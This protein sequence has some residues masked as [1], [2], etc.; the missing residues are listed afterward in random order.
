MKY[1]LS[2]VVAFLLLVPTCL[3]QDTNKSLDLFKNKVLPILD[4]KCVECHNSKDKKKGGLELDSAEGLR[5]GGSSGRVVIPHEPNKSPLLLAVS[6]SDKDLKMPPD[7]KDKLTAEEVKL[8][9]DWI[10]YGAADDRK[11][12]KVEFASHWSFQPIT[13]Y[14]IPKINSVSNP[15]D[16]FVF[17]EHSKRGILPAPEANRRDLARRLFFDLTGLPPS[18]EQV[19]KFINDKSSNAWEKLVDEAL[20]SPHYGER[21]ARYWM[22]LARYSD[23][24]GGNNNRLSDRYVY[25]WTYRDYLIN[26]FN[27]DK[28]Y[29]QFAIEQLA[30]DQLSTNFNPALAAAGF[31]SIGKFDANNDNRVDEKINTVSRTF[32]G[33]SVG[34]ARC[35]YHKFDPI[36]QEDYY[37]WHGILKGLVDSDTFPVIKDTS[38]LT[39]YPQYVKKK[40]EL[41][42]ELEGFKNSEYVKWQGYFLK[43]SPEYFRASFYNEYLSRE[44]RRD[45]LRTN[46][47]DGV[48]MSQRVAQNWIRETQ[49]KNSPFWLPYQ[50]LTASTNSSHH[51][52]ILA[53][54]SSNTNA[55]QAIISQLAR[56]T[57]GVSVMLYYESLFQ[58]AFIISTN[59]NIEPVKLAQEVLNK[60]T[61]P[62]RIGSVEDFQNFLPNQQQNTYQ[63]GLRTIT[64]KIYQHEW[65]SPA[66]PSR[67]QVLKDNGSSNSKLLI[68]GNASKPGDEVPRR[69]LVFFNHNS[70]TN[71]NARLDFAKDMTLIPTFA[72]VIVNRV[73]ASHF[74]Q[75]FVTTPDDI[76]TNAEQPELNNLL[77]W[78]CKYLQDNN[79]SLKSLHRVILTSN[80]YRQSVNNSPKYDAKDSGNRLFH[81]QN[82]G[83]LEFEYVRDAI[84]H[85]SGLLVDSVGGQSKPLSDNRR[86]LYMVIDRNRIPETWNVFDFANP[87]MTTGKRFETII[88]QQSLY[89]MNGDLAS[90]AASNLVKSVSRSVDEESKITEIYK[91][92]FQRIPSQLE[93]KIGKSYI[94]AGGS[95]QN[96]VHALLMSNELIYIN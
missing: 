36:A 17:S 63:N 24:R 29:N 38:S 67:A 1:I 28:P 93:I 32:L 2:F 14:N 61:S 80:T 19:E 37:G 74:N 87:N 64:E 71:K 59:S 35:H 23:Y 18:Y 65:D 51:K 50:K 47:I 96:Y 31:L 8:I 26:S 27:Q 42:A 73:W 92:I 13:N 62:R 53:E 22:D 40:A 68:K 55:S 46:R 83:R 5:K 54:L 56:T 4:T 60:P 41:E 81:K 25:A 86:S 70:Y 69:L 43:H 15:I 58:K 94:E 34:C 76:G 72:R 95:F 84:L 39:N 89:L 33:L 78:M 44:I 49:T 52:Q 82:V 48:A 3:G 12:K 9:S 7:E 16:R 57:N 88:P 20:A 66:T 77:N 21:W 79:W 45:Y 91:T 30:V 10:L 90:Q 75:G 85:T 6:Y 11:V